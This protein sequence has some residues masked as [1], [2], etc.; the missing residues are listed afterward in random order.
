MR[1]LIVA[2]ALMVLLSMSVLKCSGA[3]INLRAESQVSTG[4]PVTIAD[5]ADMQADEQL[6]ARIGRVIVSA[7]VPAGNQRSID[8][9]Y[10]KLKLKS[11]GLNDAVTVKG[12][13]RIS[14]TGKS[15]TITS[16]ELCEEVQN[17]VL[18][19]ASAGNCTYE[20]IIERSPRDI[21]TAAGA[22]IRIQP[23][24]L[25]KSLRL[26]PNTVAIDVLVDGKVAATTTASVQ[27]KAVADVLVTT[28]A[29]SQGEQLTEANT[30]WEQREVTRIADAIIMS[31]G[32][33]TRDWVARR[34]IPA[35][36]VLRSA[37]VMLPFDVRSGDT[38]TLVVNCG[39]VTLRTPAQCKQ[40]G[41]IGD[42]I[43]V[44]SSVSSQD[45]RAKITGA[46]TVEICR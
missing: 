31:A 28:T 43:K 19:L 12:P 38:V 15:T 30:T 7:S 4:K 9:S 1:L 42:T 24:L 11:A 3:Q 22:E 36:T 21:V 10:I 6:A 45:V 35:G 44:R 41:R 17:Y 27:V 20:V 34:T 2:L 39:R 40:D 8:T 23:R 37:D 32:G 5:V 26:G 16:A 29:V 18:G 25:S 13:D 46:G 14:V 33:E